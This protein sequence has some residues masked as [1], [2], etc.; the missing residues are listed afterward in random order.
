VTTIDNR[1]RSSEPGR[2][3]ASV[4][5]L[6]AFL[7][8]SAAVA[9]LGSLATIAQVD[10]WY[11]DADRAPW[12]PPNWLFGPAW[13]VLYT[14]MSVAAWLVWRERH[15]VQVGPALGWYV[16]QLALNSVWTPVFF[17][18]YPA[19]GSAALW[20]AFAVIVVLDVAVVVTIGLFWRI[21]RAAALLLV[22][23]LAWILFASTLNLYAAL[24]N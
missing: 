19:M 21:R 16:G 9:L 23:Y 1:I 11:A 22:P 12:S 7:A 10:G 3:V 18:L 14:L 24:A 20:L 5:V 6:I 8:I 2:K 13:T 4:L 15:R 17:A